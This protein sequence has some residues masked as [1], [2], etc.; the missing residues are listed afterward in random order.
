MGG[1]IMFI[2]A[3]NLLHALFCI[4]YSFSFFLSLSLSLWQINK[5]LKKDNQW[6][7]TTRL[8]LQAPL[9][10]REGPVLPQTWTVMWRILLLTCYVI[11]QGTL[12]P[13]SNHTHKLKQDRAGTKFLPPS[14]AVFFLPLITQCFPNHVP[15]KPHGSSVGFL[16]K[17]GIWTCYTSVF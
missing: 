10:P 8:E 17:F 9:I 6:W 13:W 7:P 1:V 12:V 2:F 14:T 3:N 5:I 15:S 16:L 4:F 11:Y